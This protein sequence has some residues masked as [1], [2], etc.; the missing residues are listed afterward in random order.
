MCACRIT[1]QVLRIM[2]V[3]I[4]KLDDIEAQSLPKHHALEVELEKLF[5]CWVESKPRK[6]EF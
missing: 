1:R 5:F 3:D 4:E 2:T 6:F